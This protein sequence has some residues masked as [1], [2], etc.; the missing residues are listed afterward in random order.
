MRLWGY[1]PGVPATL[2]TLK[3][4]YTLE[5]KISQEL[6][7]A[8]WEF[9]NF[10]MRQNLNFHVYNNFSYSKFLRYGNAKISSR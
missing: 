10:K 2:W 9:L 6:N 1:L 5:E 7:L 8:S 3:I 4:Y